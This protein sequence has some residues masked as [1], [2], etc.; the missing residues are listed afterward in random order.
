MLTQSKIHCR[1]EV[2]GKEESGRKVGRL[3]MVSV[4]F[5]ILSS[6]KRRALGKHIADTGLRNDLLNDRDRM[7]A[8]CRKKA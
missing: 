4:V 5:A 7:P 1:A 6:H 3:I 2:T 8:M